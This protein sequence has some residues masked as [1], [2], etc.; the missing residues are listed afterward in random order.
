MAL[1]DVSGYKYNSA[2]QFG[3]K[4][5]HL[6]DRLNHYSFGA[7]CQEFAVPVGVDVSNLLSKSINHLITDNSTVLSDS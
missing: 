2:S 3:F 5:T 4:Q 7:K 6:L 1:L